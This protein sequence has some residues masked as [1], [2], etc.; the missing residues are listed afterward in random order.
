MHCVV[1]VG[2]AHLSVGQLAIS[3]SKDEH[4]GGTGMQDDPS[5]THCVAGQDAESV[6]VEQAGKAFGSISGIKGY[7]P[8]LVNPPAY[9]MQV[10]E[11]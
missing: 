4:G 11:L 2:F 8:L 10:I 7:Y 3:F 6:K 9:P 1:P 5:N